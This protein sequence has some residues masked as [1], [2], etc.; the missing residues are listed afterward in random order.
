[1]N[2]KAIWSY[3]E[4]GFDILGG[5]G[6]PMMDKTAVELGLDD[7]WFTWVAAIWLFGS[8]AITTAKFMQ[9]FPY[10]L[11]RVNEER[12]ASAARQGYLRADKKSEYLPTTNGTSVAQKIWRQAGYSLAS[13]NPMSEENLQHLFNYLERLVEASLAMPQPP[14]HFY[15]SHKWE[16]YRRLGT[17]YPLENYVVLFGELAAYRD[18]M[19]IA[20][21]QAYQ[22]EG[23]SWDMFDKFYSGELLTIDGLYA[24]LKRRGLP[25]EIY[26]QDLQELIERG[27][28]IER[29]NE[30]QITPA[31]KK[32]REDVEVE[33]E[34]LF[35]APWSCLDERDLEDLMNL[36]T[37]LH[38]GLQNPKEK[39]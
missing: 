10:G 24:K 22:I 31:G 12:F 35:F 15:L 17:I 16:N 25:Q 1:M 14:S 18:D 13:I 33:T 23:H 21:W 29:A 27:W 39:M 38:D 37:Q 36:S 7:N 32:V 30:Y 5:Y 3:L 11:A 9:M 19:H 34:R 8:E 6:Y 26:T 2:K 20:A 28:V 4:D